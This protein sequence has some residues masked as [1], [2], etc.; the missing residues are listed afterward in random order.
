MRRPIIAGLLFILSVQ[1]GLA[2][3]SPPPPPPEL[4]TYPVPLLFP[5]DANESCLIG[6]FEDDPGPFHHWVIKNRVPGVNNA[7]LKVIAVG[8]NG[9]ESGAIRVN[10]VDENGPQS[11]TV[12]HPPSGQ[13]VGFLTLSLDGSKFYQVRVERIDPGPGIPA[14]HHYKLGAP[15]RR[16][17]LGYGNIRYLEHERQAWA[18]NADANEPVSVEIATDAGPGIAPQSTSTTI[19]IQNP[20]GGIVFG[21]VTLA[22][23]G[24]VSFPSP[25]AGPLVVMVEQSNG[26]FI[27]RKNSGRDRG[28]Y[29]LPCPHHQEP[30]N[31]PPDCSAAIPSVAEIW[32]PNHKMVDVSINGVTDP[33]G[34]PVT[35]RIM[36]I[37]QDEPLDTF[38]DGSFEPDGAGLGT[39]VAQVRAERSGTKKVPGN[40]RVYVIHF[41]A[42]DGKGGVCRGMVRTCVPHDQGKKEQCID[43]GQRYNSVTG[44]SEP[45]P[46]PGGAVAASPE[47]ITDS[48]V[49]TTFT[50]YDA[51]PNPF[52][53]T[54]TISFSLAED[55]P[56]TLRVFDALG[57]EVTLLVQ[58][59][60]GAG[61]H[62]VQFQA[63]H[64]PSGLYVYRL[65][66]A[67]VVQSRKLLLMK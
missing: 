10:V 16:L 15:D 44:A 47:K 8:I 5:H 62:S 54:T 6:H 25:G 11:V 3:D 50:L 18:I 13:N 66:T 34:D 35:V 20:S 9:S 48:S 27:L 65:E 56:V 63:D 17:E 43:D 37:T 14:A 33:D 22:P 39:S 12:A 40:G 21:P 45:P 46:I 60:L 29:M 41:E 57:R 59:R 2:Q 61:R 36:R 1:G 38:G 67:G 24:I 58:G 30:Q 26:H 55:A 23:N 32:P 52:N 49:P 42:S 19:S 4:F 64:L 51:F 28:V 53:P 7:T 31:R